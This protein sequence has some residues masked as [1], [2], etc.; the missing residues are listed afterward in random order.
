MKK[1][2]DI[3]TL[4][5]WVRGGGGEEADTDMV[6]QKGSR[7]VGWRRRIGADTA[8]EL[9]AFPSLGLGGLRFIFC[10]VTR[11]DYPPAV[12]L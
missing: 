2:E 7:A 5:E 3:K 10:T 12:V 1:K 11:F 8:G 9:M 4:E 6:G